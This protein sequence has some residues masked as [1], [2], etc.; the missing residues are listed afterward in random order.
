MQNC[1][2]YE[3]TEEK[4]IEFINDNSPNNSRQQSSE[5]FV[6]Q[7]S[8]FHK[9]PLVGATDKRDFSFDRDESYLKSQ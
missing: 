1:Q 3:L 2:D 7:L 4:K 9:F 8:G 6:N 5:G